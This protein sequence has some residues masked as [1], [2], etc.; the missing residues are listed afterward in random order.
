MLA[1][2]TLSGEWLRFGFPPP[3]KEGED[4]PKGAAMV[5]LTRKV[6]VGHSLHCDGIHHASGSHEGGV[7]KILSPAFEIL[8]EPRGDGHGEAG[9]LAA[10]NR[11]GE[12]VFEGFPQDE[13]GLAAAHFVVGT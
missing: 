10:K 6:F 3:S 5:G 11:F 1:H 7:G 8:L 2:L 4:G 13:F 9:F 12:I